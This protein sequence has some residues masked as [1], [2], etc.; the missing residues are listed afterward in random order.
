MFESYQLKPV[1]ESLQGKSLNWSKNNIDELFVDS[2]MLE[3][4]ANNYGLKS[5]D[6]VRGLISD[7]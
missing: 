5:F 2:Y 6:I 4:L 3:Y 7:E 1:A